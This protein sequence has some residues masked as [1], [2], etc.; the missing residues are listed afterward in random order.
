M[1]DIPLAP[2]ERILKRTGLRV[3]KE[4]TIEFAQLLE[5]IIADI[6]SEAAAEAKRNKRKTVLDQ[7]IRRAIKKIY[8]S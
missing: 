4:A 5:E 3:S 1:M 7:D 2:V 6:V 8:L